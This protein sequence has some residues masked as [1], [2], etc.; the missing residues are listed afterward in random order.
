MK[1]EVSR[2]SHAVTS[3][4]NPPCDNAVFEEIYCHDRKVKGWFIEINDIKELLAFKSKCGHEII[5]CDSC[6]EGYRE[7]EIYDDYRE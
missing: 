3:Q 6:F 7:L 1:F 5:I 2:T 4:H